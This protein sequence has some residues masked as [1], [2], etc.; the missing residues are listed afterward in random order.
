MRVPITR[1]WLCNPIIWPTGARACY[2]QLLP[3][4]GGGTQLQSNDFLEA[5]TV[6]A[7]IHRIAFIRHGQT[8][9]AADGID[10][11]RQLSDLGI[12]QARQAGTSY[13]R[14]DLLSPLFPLVMVSPAPRTIDTAK[15]FLEAAVAT[16]TDAIV[17]EIVPVDIAYDGTMQAG[18]SALFQRIGYRP[19]RDYLES[20]DAND[21]ET[22]RRL[23]GQYAHNIAEAIVRTA[24]MA[25]PARSTSTKETPP[26][27]LLFFGHA[28]YLPSA[29]LG[30]A[31]LAGV[32]QDH[33]LSCLLDSRTEEAEG[34]LVDLDRR[35]CRYLARC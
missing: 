28:V 27:T 26:S 18:G 34:Y 11:N 23:M 14:S 24:A 17:P 6:R 32:D 22:A 12:S 2:H 8:S 3:F 15:H 33:G 21:R 9:A 16:A 20:P 19:L 5:L 7:G 25:A 13:G 35:S 31:S 4:T 10:F 29:A 30:V 1:K